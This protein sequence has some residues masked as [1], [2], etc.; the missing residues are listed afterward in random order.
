MKLPGLHFGV[1]R[2]HNSAF[3]SALR[4]AANTR[5]YLIRQGIDPARLTIRSWGETQLRVAETNRQ[6]YARNR[7]VE[8][9][10]QD[11]RGLE[12][13]FVDQEGDLQVE[14]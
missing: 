9:V 3:K 2:R 13:N 12:I 8:F 10:F 5:D 7:R 6:N 14:P 4:R 1:P 11:V